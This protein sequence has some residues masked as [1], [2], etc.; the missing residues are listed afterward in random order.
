MIHE[1]NLF[2]NRTEVNDLF[3]LLNKDVEDCSANPLSISH[4]SYVVPTCPAFSGE[5]NHLSN[6]S[7]V[8]AFFP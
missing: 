2:L 6:S 1:C 7:I 5:P 3:K 4:K 8:N